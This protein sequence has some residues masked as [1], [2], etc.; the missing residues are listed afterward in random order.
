M[1]SVDRLE[2]VC[3]TEPNELIRGALAGF[4]L[5]DDGKSDS[6]LHNISTPRAQ[7]SA[8]YKGT[9]KKFAFSGKDPAKT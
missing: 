6:N 3:A 7:D 2:V 5:A 8:R 1:E 4:V 9:R